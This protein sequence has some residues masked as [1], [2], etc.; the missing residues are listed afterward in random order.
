MGPFGL[1]HTAV[2]NIH[3]GG[4]LAPKRIYKPRRGLNDISVL[5]NS[6]HVRSLGRDKT[7]IWRIPDDGIGPLAWAERQAPRRSEASYGGNWATV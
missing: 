6:Y 7:V 5:P 3:H 1:W 2:M 4:V